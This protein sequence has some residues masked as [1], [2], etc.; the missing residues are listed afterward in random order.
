VK[1]I[2]F[3]VLRRGDEGTTDRAAELEQWVRERLAD[4]KRPRRVAFLSELPKTATG[5]IQRYRL[6]ELVAKVNGGGEA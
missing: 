5:K 3:V 4:F 2:A 1:P 6:R